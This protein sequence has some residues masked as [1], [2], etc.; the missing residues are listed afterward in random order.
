MAVAD[1]TDLSVTATPGTPQTFVAK[2]A[3]PVDTVT[4]D[5]DATATLA[6]EDEAMRI[7]S[8]GSDWW[9]L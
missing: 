2:D 3:A 6:F 7:I 8:D 9:I 5:G 1:V 4:I